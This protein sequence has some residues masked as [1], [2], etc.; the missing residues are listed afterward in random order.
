[1][2]CECPQSC[3]NYCDSNKRIEA[4]QRADAQLFCMPFVMLMLQLPHYHIIHLCGV[5]T[6]IVIHTHTITSLRVY[7]EATG[8]TAYTRRVL[9]NN[10]KRRDTES[11][12]LLHA[13]KRVRATYETQKTR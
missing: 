8:I 9:R 13:K 10:E 4:S 12:R 3:R 2:T 6:N 7:C 11:R 1:M 5:I